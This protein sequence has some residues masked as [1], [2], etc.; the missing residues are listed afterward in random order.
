MRAKTL[1]VVWHG[2]EPVFSV[3]FH[4]SGILATAG[5]DKD[6]KVSWQMKALKMEQ[7]QLFVH[8]VGRALGGFQLRTRVK[9]TSCSSPRSNAQ[10]HNLSARGSSVGDRS[11]GRCVGRASWRMLLF[12]LRY[13]RRRRVRCA[14]WQ[15]APRPAIP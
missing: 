8:E 5:A 14:R 15:C 13:E 2:K 4:P 6:I 11:C 1:Q 12:Y 9:L 3:D 10:I 7:Q